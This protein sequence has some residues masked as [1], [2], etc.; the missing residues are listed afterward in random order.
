MADL[1]EQELIQ[2]LERSLSGNQNDLKQAMGYIETKKE[3]QLPQF[4]YIC[5]KILANQNAPQ[6]ARIQAGLQA[7]NCLSSTVDTSIIEEKWKNQVQDNIKQEMKNNVLNSLGTENKR[8]S[9]AAQL[10]AAIAGLE[11]PN[12]NW[13]D[14]TKQLSERVIAKNGTEAAQEASLEAIGYICAD[15]KDEFIADYTSD[16]LTAIVHGMKAGSSMSVKLAATNAMN[17]ALEFISDNFEKS[18]ERDY[19]MQVVCEA[20]QTNDN[21]VKRSSLE[22]LVKIVSLYYDHMEC[23]M[24]RALFAITMEAMKS[25]NDDVCLQGIEFWSNVCDEEYDLAYETQESWERGQPPS[26][27]SQHYAKGALEYLTPILCN[28]LA[29]QDEADCEDD[30]NPS[31][32]A[33][34]CLMLLAQCTEDDI[35]S[36]VIPFVE[37]NITSPDWKFRDAAV[38]ALGSIL[39]GPTPSKVE[40][41]LQPAMQTLIALFDDESVAVRDSTAWCMGKICETTPRLVF[42]QSVFEGLLGKLVEGLSAAPRVATNICWAISSLVEACYEQADTDEETGTVKTYQL[43]Q[44]FSPMIQKLLETTDRKDSGESNLRAASYEALMEMIKN[45]PDDCYNCVL[46]TTSEIMKRIDQLLNV[47]DTNLNSDQKSQYADLQSLLC[48]ALQS[49]LRKIKEQDIAGMSDQIMTALLMMLQSSQNQDT[50]QVKKSDDEAN[51]GGVH[52]DA[53]LAIGTLTEVTGERFGNYMN[54]FKPFLIKALA[55]YEEPAVCQAAVGVIGD[56][57]RALGKSFAAHAEELMT[58]LLT[59]LMNPKLD[60]SVRPHILSLFGDIAMAVSTEFV[61]YLSHCMNSLKQASSVEIDKTDFDQVD[62]LNELHESVING[63]T[64]ILH[65]LKGQDTIPAPAIF[66]IVAHLEFI[67]QLIK[68]ISGDSERTDSLVSSTCGLI[69]DIITTLVTE[70][71]PQYLEKSNQIATGLYQFMNDEVVMKMLSEAR[72][73]SN[74]R[75][76]QVA[77]WASRELRKLKQKVEQQGGN[78]NTQKGGNQLR[79]ANQFQQQHVVGH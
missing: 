40:S 73:H 25:E 32:S 28:T 50:K 4:L 14:L 27:N 15:I 11:L 1:N 12:N 45:S 18:N 5:T 63:I 38:M 60:K 2:V 58:H 57:S 37:K 17:N 35:L 52:E 59:A 26:R 76:K 6:I 39:D 61:R 29:R 51:F 22:C 66:E 62:Y 74:Q 8:P 75:Q 65:G 49:V 71:P 43:S 77:V 13:P 24:G 9:S 67:C 78:T 34:V 19:I 69:G 47:R 23:Y 36:K 54:S 56:I 20:T 48:A 7:K 44:Y 16:I 21:R 31:K 30:W 55:S 3:Q 33:G 72:V 41:L 42:H 70:C 79:N 64:G 68:K 10:I 46:S 53:L